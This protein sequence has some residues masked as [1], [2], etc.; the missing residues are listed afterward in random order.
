MCVFL[1]V[2]ISMCL[3]LSECFCSR[4][5]VT[6][7]VLPFF[8]VSLFMFV[9]LSVSPS[10]FLSLCI[11]LY[12]SLTI[13][14]YL[15]ISL[16][17]CISLYMSLTFCVYLFACLYL[18]FL[19]SHVSFFLLFVNYFG[20]GPRI[21]CLKWLLKRKLFSVRAREKNLGLACLLFLP[22]EPKVVASRPD[23]TAG[24]QVGSY[25]LSKVM[26]KN[27]TCWKTWSLTS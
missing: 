22:H 9:C 12:M 11:S 25:W 27:N 14:V 13:C 16:S 19:P 3:S 15:F 4:V 21:D 24:K 8:S 26:F 6:L 2:F 18:S 5:C 17:L 7:Y 23:H 1:S 10:M 20:L